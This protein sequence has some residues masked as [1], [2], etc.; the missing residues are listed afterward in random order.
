M[1]MASIYSNQEKGF[2]FVELMITVGISSVVM[3]G[4]AIV[5]VQMSRDMEGA[6]QKTAVMEVARR[7]TTALADSS[8]CTE[9]LKVANL[10]SFDP[11]RMSGDPSPYP[12]MAMNSIPSQIESMSANALRP[13][14]L[15]SNTTPASLQSSRVL[16]N[17]IKLVDFSCGAS[18]C[19]ATAGLTNFNTFTANVEVGF[20]SSKSA[21]PISPQ[22][23]KIILLTTGATSSA[24]KPYSC[25]GAKCDAGTVTNCRL[26]ATDVGLTTGTCANGTAGSCSYTCKNGMW[27]E[28]FANFCN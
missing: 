13:A 17:S 24:Q 21:L 20:D 12:Q 26:A 4:F 27:G 22:K 2:S 25:L 16:I 8:V 9:M 19:S 3:V 6:R 11:S 1:K 18:S 7:V 23:F 15:V 14:A 5:L 28:P 10:P